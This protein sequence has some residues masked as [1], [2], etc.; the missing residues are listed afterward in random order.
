MTNETRAVFISYIELKK[1]FYG[2]DEVVIKNTI[3]DMIENIDEYGLNTI[4]LQIR[5]F[6]DAI[7]PSDIFPSSTMIVENAGD[8]LPLDILDYFIEV[9][10][11]KGM[12]LHA[13]INP[14]RISSNN[15]DEI[16]PLSPAYNLESTSAVKRT[17]NGIFYNPADK[18]VEELILSGIEEILDHYDVDGILFDDYFYPDDTIDQENYEQAKLENPNLTLSEFRLGVTSSLVKNT[19]QLVKGKDKNILFG[20]SPEGNIDNN[21]SKNYIDTK[22]FASEDGYVDYLMPQIYFGFLNSTKPFTNTLKEWDNLITASN[23]KLIP[24]LAFYKAGQVDYYAKEG[25]DEWIQYNNIIM[26]EVQA[27]RLVANYDGF[28]IFRYDSIFADNLTE[29]AFSE[30]ENLKKIL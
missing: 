18:E 28:S 30:K 21:Y 7:Y 25:Q 13:W 10:H 12:E 27:S 20:I 26:R 1:Y 23:V 14:Y 9:T 16:S 15:Q 6:S 19:Y 3:D 4:L 8:P 2:K 17:E 11:E 5:S 24:A 29:N 22:L